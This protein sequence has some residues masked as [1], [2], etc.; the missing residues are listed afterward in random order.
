MSARAIREHD[1]KLILSKYVSSLEGG[2]HVARIEV[3]TK[4]IIE[5]L[6]ET[7]PATLQ[8]SLNTQVASNL[9]ESDVKKQLDGVFLRVES[10]HP[11][12]SSKKLV[13]KPDQL[14]K[15]RGK[16]GLLKLNCTWEEVK[17]WISERAGKEIEVKIGMFCFIFIGGF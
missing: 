8:G 6:P 13:V 4:S 2:L 10:Q 1:G 16:G 12:L 11:W 5:G 14:I 9:S 3:E 15:R 17:L 7:I